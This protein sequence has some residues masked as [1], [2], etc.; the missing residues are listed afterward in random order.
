MHTLCLRR[1]SQGP[2]QGPASIHPRDGR[3]R[4]GGEKICRFGS[5]FALTKRKPYTY[6]SVG[7]RTIC[8][9]FLKRWCRKRKTQRRGRSHHF[10]WIAI[11]ILSENQS[12]K[13][14]TTRNCAPR[15]SSVDVMTLCGAGIIPYG[16]E[17]HRSQSWMR[18]HLTYVLKFESSRTTGIEQSSSTQLFNVQGPCPVCRFARS[19]VEHSPTNGSRNSVFYRPAATASSSLRH[20]NEK[21]SRFSLHVLL[22]Y[23]SGVQH[24]EGFQRG[25]TRPREAT[26]SRAV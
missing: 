17:S 5:E 11:W 16:R 22:E 8:R 26:E 1:S 18:H 6:R 2:S 19:A 7:E 21:T 23:M 12:W 20:G 25:C 14:R 3:G 4:R 24:G 9:L 10:P 13:S 15:K